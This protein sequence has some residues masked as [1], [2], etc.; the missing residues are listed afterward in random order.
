CQ[1]TPPP[2]SERSGPSSRSSPRPTRAHERARSSSRTARWPSTPSIGCCRS[3]ATSSIPGSDTRPSSVPISRERS[4]RSGKPSPVSRWATASW[5]TPWER[6]RAATTRRRAP[7]RNTP[8][9]SPAWQHR[10]PK[11]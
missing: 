6:T 4:S 11:P 8:L 3:S 7:S 9:S 1:P 10:S 5:V 2:G